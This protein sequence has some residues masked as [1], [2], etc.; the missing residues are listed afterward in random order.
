MFLTRQL[1]L[2]CGCFHNGRV[3]DVSEDSDQNEPPS[4]EV[5]I[6]SNDQGSETSKRH[7]QDEPRCLQKSWPRRLH[8]HAE[9]S[10]TSVE[11]TD[12]KFNTCL[13]ST[14]PIPSHVFS[15]PPKKPTQVPTHTT[16]GDNSAL[17]AGIVGGI[18]LV[19]L[20]VI[21][22]WVV[23]NLERNTNGDLPNPSRASRFSRSLA[24]T[25]PP[26]VLPSTKPEQSYQMLESLGLAG[27]PEPVVQNTRP[28]GGSANSSGSGSGIG[29]GP[30]PY[31]SSYHPAAQGPRRPSAS[32]RSINAPDTRRPSDAYDH[33]QPQS[34]NLHPGR[35]Q[36]F[37]PFME[38]T[39]PPSAASN[40]YANYQRTSLENQPGHHGEPMRYNEGVPP[41]KTSLDLSY[42]NGPYAQK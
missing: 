21:V 30:P 31:P 36:Q 28:Y 5:H 20:L 9:W 16:M 40:G 22:G 11:D 32:A 37:P 10:G 23:K 26:E 13:T 42:S 17:I 27:G 14:P 33:Q 25:S 19:I 8:L 7:H 3:S 6:Q 29:S 2:R 18:L 4:K 39:F 24:R 15:K 1:W 41:P 35:Q 38:D 12:E 34:T